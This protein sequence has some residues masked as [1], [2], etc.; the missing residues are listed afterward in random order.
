M[1]KIGHQPK[2]LVTSLDKALSIL[3]IMMLEGTNMPLMELSSKSG[4]GKGT[5]HRILD[6]LKA[7]GYA[8]QDPQTKEY[9]FGFRL[10]ELASKLEEKHTKK[11]HLAR[12]DA[13]YTERV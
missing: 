6:T 8:Q 11:R 4:L 12:E 13:L 2:S 5:V 7:R 9:G 1:S 3:E 10:F